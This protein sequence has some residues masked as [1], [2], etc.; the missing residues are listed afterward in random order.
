MASALATVGTVAARHPSGRP[1]LLT[2][3]AVRAPRIM[4]WGATV[5][6]V[7][8]EAIV[9]ELNPAG[10]VAEWMRQVGSAHL[11]TAEP[12]RVCA[13]A[14]AAG[15]RRVF[16]AIAAGVA[17]AASH[18]EILRRLI[19]APVDRGW[20]AAKLASPEMPSVLRESRSPFVGVSPVAA[21]CVA[22]LAGDA[23]RVRPWWRP[24]EPEKPLAEGAQL[25]RQALARGI[26]GRA[27]RAGGRVS[28]QLSG[29][30][31]SAAIALLAAEA[32]PLMVTTAGASPVDEDLSWARRI[33]RTIPAGEHRIFTVA[34]MPAFFARLE[35]PVAGMDEPCSF[36]AGGARQ[37]FAGAALAERA[38]TLHFNG[39]GGDEVL[40]APWAFL[41]GL[42]RR[43]P[44]LGWRHLRGFAA[45]R[46]LRASAVMR[47]A[48]RGPGQFDSWLE[49]AGSRL[50]RE[51]VAAAAALGWEAPP[52][53]PTWASSEAAELAIAALAAAPR[54]P[55]HPDAAVH[56]AVVRIRASAY[57]AALYADAMA[58]A[59]AP[60]VMPFFDHEVLTACLSTRPEVR[61]DPWS[62]KPLL[63]NALQR[64]VPT[65][66]LARRTKGHYNT[67]IYRG[68]RTHRD[69]VR[70]ML[71]E[72]RLVEL[73]LVDQQVLVD[74]LAA[75]GP[76]GLP[77]A[78]VT[79]LIALEIWLRQES[80]P[81]TWGDR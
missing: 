7:L 58:V 23:V 1:W 68:W 48:L 72:S 46:G 77:P 63:R 38:V 34:E 56:A 40:L 25:L 11:V 35:H 55:V 33:A 42:L 61:T 28:V 19:D 6:A 52:L 21:G 59:G 16:T 5:V 67:D 32:D 8:G 60:T 69:D 64:D 57:R 76:S 36:A 65:E 81:L 71:A 51:P 14:D 66:L 10:T 54:T 9:D 41:S 22:E 47:E 2:A 12:G 44:R 18:A 4:R 62:P 26:C 53:L 20:V 80:P 24:P 17:V 31:D 70:A 15:F 73:G 78:F 30:L 49:R 43:A 74:E 45:L 29:G 50:R 39:Q 27:R 37:R 13:V 3:P 75:F 79:D